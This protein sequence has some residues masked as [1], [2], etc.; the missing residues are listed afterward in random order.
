MSAPA[1]P[2]VVAGDDGLAR[3]AWS[4]S[5]PEYR[6]YHD[7][8]WGTPQHDPTRLYEK[9]CLEGFQAGLSW[10]TIL[11][12]RPAFRE[13]FHG[14]HPERVAAMTEADVELLLGD[15]RIIRHRGKIEATIANA[16]AVLALER[17]LDELLWGFAPPPRGAAP[18]SFTEV[19]ATTPE[20]AAMSQTLRAHGFRF[21]GPTTMY[22]L[23]QST[24]MVDDHL[25]GCFR[26]TTEPT[27]AVA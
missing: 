17:P 25:A 22:A 14:F 26:A 21:V 19:P 23:M 4:A 6:R 27:S 13:V 8:E 20:S 15:A 7:E 5:D 24:G 10:I 2:D 12:R 1:R 11:R 9:L 3:C 18:V 16:R